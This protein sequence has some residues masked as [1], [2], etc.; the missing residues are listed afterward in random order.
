MARP[1]HEFLAEIDAGLL[2]EQLSKKMAEVVRG[3]TEVEKLGSLTLTL[4]VKPNGDG[5][6]FVDARITQKI[7][8]QPVDTSMFFAGADGSLSRNSPRQVE[9]VKKLEAVG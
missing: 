9:T 6:V 5:K 4:S 1:F 8:E 3:V 7:P 2:L